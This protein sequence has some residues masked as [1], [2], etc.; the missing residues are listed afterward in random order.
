VDKGWRSHDLVEEFI[1]LI[2][3]GRLPA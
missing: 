2:G 1:S 3:D